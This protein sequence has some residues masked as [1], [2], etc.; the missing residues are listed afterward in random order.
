MDKVLKMKR[1]YLIAL[2]SLLCFTAL[3]VEAHV[4]IGP[5]TELVGPVGVKKPVK[6]YTQAV[7]RS[8][9]RVVD[10]LAEVTA[11]NTF[12]SPS[13]DFPFQAG[14]PNSPEAWL[15][16]MLDPSR[17]GIV[18]KHP[19]LLAEW[20]DAISEPRFMTALASV[21]MTPQTYT[22]TLGKMTEPATSR[23]WAEFADPKIMMRWM[24]V[25]MD[26]AF[27]Q[28]VFLRMTDAGKLRRWAGY[29]L[30]SDKAAISVET[31]KAAAVR[32]STT[33]QGEEWLQLPLPLRETNH[34][35]WLLNSANYRY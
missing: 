1:R 4:G 20:L 22:N 18:A 5:E 19:E 21:V 34:N 15:A 14:I 30:P 12:T 6:L 24:A 26:P 13:E 3:R 11:P 27:Y 17:N 2:A 25:G 7:V 10:R 35:P 8:D 9:G 23:N 33:K 32:I 28:A 31:G 16:R 29:P